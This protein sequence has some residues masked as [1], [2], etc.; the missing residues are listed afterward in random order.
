MTP[1]NHFELVLEKGKGIFRLAPT[2]VPRAFCVPGKRLRL[3]PDDYYAL[4]TQRGG[5]DERWFA[6]TS[7]AENGPDAPHD[8]G[9]SFIVFEDGG[10]QQK[11]LLR[12]AVEELKAD[13]IG[14]EVWK[15]YGRW[16]A[17]AKFFDNQSA[18]P[19]HLHHRRQH[20]ALIHQSEK[21][22]SYYFPPQ[23]NNH[24]GDFP[25]TFFG[26]QPQVSKAQFLEQ[27]KRF[28][29]GDNRITDLSVAYRLKLGTAW[30]VPAGTLHAP[31]SLCT[32]EPQ[33]SSD[34]GAFYQSM[35]GEMPVPESILWNN[36]PPEKKG[37]YEFLVEL[38][39]WDANIDPDFGNHHFMEPRPVHPPEEM[40][41]EGYQELWIC[42]KNP[43]YA[44]KE[45]TIFPG[46][47]AVIKDS[48][49]YGLITVQGHGTL[50]DFP[51]EAPG[52]IRFGQLTNDEF[53]VSEPAARKGVILHNLSPLEPLVMLKNLGPYHHAT[54]NMPV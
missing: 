51:I 1:Q 18:L 2:W 27:L 31:G 49:A 4:G 16:P 7:K 8:E 24:A 28:S 36:V 22:E 19:F 34:V 12:D 48:G 29:Q 46:K 39:D 38:I 41:A 26:L 35:M 5:I 17:F 14:E 45:L 23:Y 47:T 20:A 37:D 6:S 13:L 44:A 15:E 9:L 33:W 40:Q 52:M 50:G 25:H 32:Y 53:F 42:Y 10:K 43:A 21:P 11:L 54:T 30:D 3:H